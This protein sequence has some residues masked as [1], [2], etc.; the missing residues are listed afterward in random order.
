MKIEI[1]NVKK[2]RK[3]KSI[4]I[5]WRYFCSSLIQLNANLKIN[6]TIQKRKINLIYNVPF[7]TEKLSPHLIHLCYIGTQIL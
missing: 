5:L 4:L 7:R 6:L 1:F 3:K 2:K